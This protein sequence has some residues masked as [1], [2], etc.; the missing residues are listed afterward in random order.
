MFLG[1]IVVIADGNSDCVPFLRNIDNFD[2][3]FIQQY[4]RAFKKYSQP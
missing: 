3:K 4:L 1:E 2:I